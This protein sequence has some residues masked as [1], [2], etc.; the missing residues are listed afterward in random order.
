MQKLKLV[1]I[2][3]IMMLFFLLFL[4]VNYQYI[5]VL[6]EVF[7]LPPPCQKTKHLFKKGQKLLQILFCVT[8]TQCYINL[9]LKFQP[10]PSSRKKLFENV[11]KKGNKKFVTDVRP[12]ETTEGQT[13]DNISNL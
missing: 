1:Q 4:S 6:Y 9:C 13:L 7:R 5:K 12:S 8:I 10:N 3:H 2:K 11:K